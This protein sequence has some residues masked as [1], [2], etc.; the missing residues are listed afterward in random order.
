TQLLERFGDRVEG[1]AA[2]AAIESGVVRRA[3]ELEIPLYPRTLLLS[4]RGRS[5][6]REATLAARGGGAPFRLSVDAVVLAHRRLPHPQLFFQAGARM[7]WRSAGGAYF[8]EVDGAGATTVPGL[9]AIGEAAGVADPSDFLRSGLRAVDASLGR[10]PDGSAVAR[11]D[12]ARPH[13]IDGYYRE[14]LARPR[15]GG[16]WVACSCEDVLLDEVEEASRRGYRGIEVVKRYTSLGTGL[17]QG[18]YCLPDTLL[19]LA[20]LENRAAAEVG[21]ITQR[22]P[23]VPTPLNSLAGLPLDSESEVP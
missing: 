13:E 15:T 4:V 18:R 3:T 20:R 19:L 23:V 14:L 21:Y 11:L 5:G 16:K 6:L 22:P 9:Y 1:I 7:Q 17:C 10:T 8:P 12:E 2:P